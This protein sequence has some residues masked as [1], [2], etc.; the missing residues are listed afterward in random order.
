MVQGQLMIKVL[1]KQHLQKQRR[2]PSPESKLETCLKAKGSASNSNFGNSRNA[3][4][5]SI[6]RV[7]WRGYDTITIF[8]SFSTFIF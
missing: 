3:K 2:Y 8:S 5:V 7:N 1:K 6:V 4:Q